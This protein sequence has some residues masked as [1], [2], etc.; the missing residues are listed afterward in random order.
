LL[1]EDITEHDLKGVPERWHLYRVLE[2]TTAK[3][4]FDCEEDLTLRRCWSACCGKSTAR[5]TGVLRQPQ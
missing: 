1:F 3:L 5:P 2:S 4:P